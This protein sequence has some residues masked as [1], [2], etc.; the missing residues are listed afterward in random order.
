MREKS[1]STA[2]IRGAFP[3]TIVKHRAHLHRLLSLVTL[4]LLSGC[5]GSAPATS[6]NA[7]QNIALAAS[8]QAPSSAALD[9]KHDPPLPPAP[10]GQGRVRLEP[11][12]QYKHGERWS[13]SAAEIAA[14]DRDTRR[15]FTVNVEK[16]RIDILD[17]TDPDDL[18]PVGHCDVSQYGQ[19]T[20][21]TIYNGLVAASVPAKSKRDPGRVVLLN[22]EGTIQQVLTVGHEPDMLTFSP[23]GRWLLVANEGEPE[24]DYSFDPEGSVSLIDVTGDVAEITQERVTTLDFRHFNDQ[25]DTLDPSVRIFG[26]NASV[27][28]D[29]EPEYIVVSPD[30]QTA[31]VACQENNCLAI[32]DLTIPRITRI[33]GLGFKDH[34]LDGNWLDASDKDD[35]I[36]IRPWPVFGM[37]QVDG[38]AVAEIDGQVWLFTANDG[39]DRDYPGGNEQCRVADLQLNPQQFP[40]AAE[41]QSKKHLGRLRV[42][43]ALGDFDGDG[44]FEALYCYGGRSFAVWTP[45]VEQVFDSGDQFERILADLHPEFFNSDHENLTFDDRSDNKGPEPES[46]TIGRIG[47]RSYAFIGLERMGGCLVYDVSH[48]RQPVF[49]SYVNTRDFTGDLAA[50]AASDLGPEGVL[51]IPA[52]DHPGGVPLL[53]V[54]HEISGT[55]RVFRVVATE[56]AVTA[57]AE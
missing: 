8:V 38:M 29:L 20:S 40:N 44:Q 21:V 54:S 50:A 22:V 13:T 37:Y 31:W 33:V 15:L 39:K 41:L 35:R 32:L 47:G 1:A 7:A 9:V 28:Q 57:A 23:D 11:A 16:S 10:V 45:E 2:A 6:P 12:G 49:E 19:P 34:S 51:F 46:V 52:E 43:N 4:A 14:Y 36:R 30:S 48:P 24:P 55:T 26:P 53:V 27:A 25:R 18:K 42:T 17:L 3:A 56:P 5:G